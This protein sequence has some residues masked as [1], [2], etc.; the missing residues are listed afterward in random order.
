MRCFCSNFHKFQYSVNLYSCILIFHSIVGLAD[1]SVLR[2]GPI[3]KSCLLSG[4]KGYLFLYSFSA[5][6]AQLE[7]SQIWSKPKSSSAATEQLF[8]SKRLKG[9]IASSQMTLIWEIVKFGSNVSLL[10]LN[11]HRS[12]ILA[13]CFESIP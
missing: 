10:G 9:E 6:Q 8:P 12:Y 2:E 11:S 13:E 5:R 7:F 4:H 3:F 1:S